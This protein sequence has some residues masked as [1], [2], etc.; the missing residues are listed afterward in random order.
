MTWTDLNWL[1]WLKSLSWLKNWK[2]WSVSGTIGLRS[3][4]TLR[5]FETSGTLD[6]I[7]SSLINSLGGSDWNLNSL[8]L[9]WFFESLG[10]LWSKRLNFSAVQNLVQQQVSIDVFKMWEFSVF[11]SPLGQLFFESLVFSLE[12][13]NLLSQDMAFIFCDAVFFDP[14]KVS[15]FFS[16]G[17]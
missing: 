14:Q 9:D 2:F 5:L 16:C 1:N 4:E 3:S 8:N 12:S 10:K 6:R 15:R 13:V 7:R 11:V 17:L